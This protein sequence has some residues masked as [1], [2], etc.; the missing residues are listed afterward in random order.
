MY[1]AA[2]T[3]GSQDGLPEV[4]RLRMSSGVFRQLRW[5]CRYKLAR[6]EMHVGVSINFSQI[7]SIKDPLHLHLLWSVPAASW[8]FPTPAVAPCGL[9]GQARVE[10]RLESMSLFQKVLEQF[11]SLWLSMLCIQSACSWLY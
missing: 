4:I 6:T 9:L 11:T 3:A 7:A 1:W 2:M 8:S 5:F 10:S